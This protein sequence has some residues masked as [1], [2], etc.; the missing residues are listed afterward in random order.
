LTVPL[1]KIA[2]ISDCHIRAE[3]LSCGFPH[4]HLAPNI[5]GAK[6]FPRVTKIRSSLFIADF[7]TQ[8]SSPSD[9]HSEKARGYPC[10]EDNE[11]KGVYKF[12]YDNY[13]V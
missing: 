9:T 5:A 1:K 6:A 4:G 8:K 13:A 2:S 12:V 10:L 7:L 3:A 11:R